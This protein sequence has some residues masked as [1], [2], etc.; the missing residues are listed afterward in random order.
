MAK[1]S[2]VAQVNESHVSTYD[3]GTDYLRSTDLLIERMYRSPKLVIKDYYPPFTLRTQANDPITEPVLA[4]EVNKSNPDIE[5]ISR[6]KFIVNKTNQET[7]RIMTGTNVGLKTI[8]ETIV[9]QARLVKGV[10]GGDVVGVRII[11]RR[12][13]K[14]RAKHMERL[15]TKAVWAGGHRT[16]ENPEGEPPI[17]DKPHPEDIPF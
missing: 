12:G 3:A 8:G 15:G 13:N 9:L 10:G 1:K 2:P 5:H 14:L 16:E 6:K 17:E 7:L 4:F 11:P